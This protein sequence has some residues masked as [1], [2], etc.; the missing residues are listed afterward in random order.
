MADS[1]RDPQPGDLLKSGEEM[2]AVT[3]REGD[4]VGWLLRLP[5]GAEIGGM[6]TSDE[7]FSMVSNAT[8]SG[9]VKVTRRTFEGA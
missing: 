6:S 9:T 2:V 5:N 7:W 4:L 1:R 8:P 3:S